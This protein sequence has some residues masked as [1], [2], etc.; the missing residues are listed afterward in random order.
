[1]NQ[2]IRNIA[3]QSLV[4]LVL[5]TSFLLIFDDKLALPAWV[6]AVGRLHPMVLHFP[7]ALL[8][9]AML[10]QLFRFRADN[11]A[12]VFY[13]RFSDTLYLTG[14][15]LAGITV[16]MGVFLSR[17]D[18]YA[19]SV[20]SWH[21]WTGAGIFFFGALTY[22]LRNVRWYQ[23]RVAQASSMLTITGLLV[24]GHYG[25]TLTHGDNF[26]LAPLTEATQQPV[27]SLEEALVFEHVIQPIFEQK[28]VSCH[29]AEKQKGELRLTDAASIRKGGKSGAFFVA[30]NPDMSRFLQRIHLP[31]EEKEH[32]PP[33]GK[34]QLSPQ[35]MSLLALWVRGNAPFKGKL[36]DLAS[37]DSFRIAA[38][39]YLAPRTTTEE[40]FDFAEADEET[41]QKL[42]NDYRTVA[43]LA[44]NSPALSV[45]I[46]N[47]NAFTPQQLDELEAIREQ[48]VHLNVAKMPVTDAE[49]K[50][51]ARLKNL[52]KLNLNFTDVTPAGLREL[53]A[54]PHLETLTLAGTPM[55][56]KELSAQLGTLKALKNITLWNTGLTPSE[57]DKL[58][59]SHRRIAFIKGFTDDGKNLLQLNPPQVRNASLVFNQTLPVQLVHPIKGVEIRYTTDGT[60]PDSVTSPVF[61]EKT[62]QEHTH[63]TARAYKEGWYGS[64]P[65]AFDFLKNT[66]IPD[67]VRL[68]YPLNR[69]HL[70]EGAHTFFDG[71]LGVIG[72]NN[73]A[74][75]NFW[76]GVRNNDL[77]L[78]SEFKQPVQISSV[79]LHYMIEE[80]TGIFPPELVEVWGGTHPDRLTLLTKFK[81]TPPKKGDKPTLKLAEGKFPKQSI[82]YLKIVAKPVG[83]IPDWHRSK[84][85]KALLLVDEMFIN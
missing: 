79:G 40:V 69:V 2:K 75:A 73:P 49:L 50:T 28:C 53:A 65:I 45:N 52:R 24:T 34:S 76:A 14:V 54:L 58:S 27:V 67:S 30:G 11:A 10:L 1:M 15:L 20:L 7:L 23:G 74:W 33:K 9:L 70:A 57:I 81:P 21:K 12:N 32:M 35:E 16:V 31:L 8:I 18:G 51:I 44:I 85:K 43:P 59:T 71:K 48:V 41:I 25:A 19:G 47:R 84:G 17:E 56:Y 36:T 82:T 77:G 80:D 13:Q 61:T 37:T 83:S 46:Y 3:E 42:N 66:F 39:A 4:V 29:N 22:W 72:A 55:K 60:E 5:F 68:L 6:Q 38:T 26:V 64:E 63:L 78:I 62:L